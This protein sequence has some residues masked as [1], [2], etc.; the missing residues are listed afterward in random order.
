[1]KDPLEDNDNPVGKREGYILTSSMDIS[2]LQSMRPKQV[3]KENP[4]LLEPLMIVMP[5]TR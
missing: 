1:M 4:L 3:R 2:D 5:N